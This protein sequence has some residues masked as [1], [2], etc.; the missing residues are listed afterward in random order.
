LMYDLE[1]EPVEFGLSF[2]NGERIKPTFNAP[3]NP[4]DWPYGARIANR[5]AP[6]S[7]PA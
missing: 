5:S 7:Q 6:S 1:G 4:D 3:V 2:Y